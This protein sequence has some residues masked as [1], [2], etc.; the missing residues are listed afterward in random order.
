MKILERAQEE[1]SG[2][3]T[4]HDVHA[5]CDAEN[6]TVPKMTDIIE[7][8]KDAGYFASRTSFSPISIRTDANRQDIVSIIKELADKHRPCSK[9]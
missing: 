5:I 3:P 8:L 2:P 4:Y 9:A 7:R 1:M 6:I